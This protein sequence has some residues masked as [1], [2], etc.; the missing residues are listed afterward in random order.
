MSFER[1]W[2]PVDFGVFLMMDSKLEL[3]ALH[4]AS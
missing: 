3:G 2:S 1:F 4:V